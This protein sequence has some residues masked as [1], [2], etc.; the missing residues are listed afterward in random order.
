MRQQLLGYL[1]NA[2]DAAER[3]EVERQLAGNPRWQ[4][5]LEQLRELLRSLEQTRQEYEPA[6]D[7]VARTVAR[8]E[9][10]EEQQRLR[11]AIEVAAATRAYH[12][13]D[14]FFGIGVCIVLAMLF[15]PAVVG[16]RD[17]ARRTMC[18][19]NLRRLGIAMQ[20]YAEYFQTAPFIPRREE[21]SFAGFVP[22]LL[23]DMG[24]INEDAVV[25]CPAVVRVASPVRI[26]TI[27]ELAQARASEL[28]QLQRMAGGDYAYTLGVVDNGI[29]RAARRQGRRWFGWVCDAPDKDIS[30]VRVHRRAF[31][32]LF[33]DGH[34]QLLRTSYIPLTGDDVLRNSRGLVAA[35]LH[36]QDSVLGRSEARP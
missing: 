16:S 34:I 31:N 3:E 6:G 29:Y 20:V 26:P 7:L 2:L 13:A 4:R 14:L 12:A 36:S 11:P 22:V 15:F 5:E 32:V 1:L 25:R 23:R 18:Q 33:E 8:V 9:H 21:F 35:G 24:L 19:E 17:L 30:V 27:A 10:Y 28:A